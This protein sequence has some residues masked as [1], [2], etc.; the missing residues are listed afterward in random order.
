MNLP[1]RFLGDT[2]RTCVCGCFQEN[3]VG[4]KRCCFNPRHDC[5]AYEEDT[6]GDLQGEVA[7]RDNPAA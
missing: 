7:G 6:S 3:H 2:S 4:G 1:P 5:E